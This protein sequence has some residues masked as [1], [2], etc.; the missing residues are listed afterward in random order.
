MTWPEFIASEIE[1]IKPMMPEGYVSHRL[2]PDDA[3]PTDR[4]HREAWCDVTPE[5]VI[6]IDPARIKA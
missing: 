5:L 6:D 4:T 3:I 2:M 1:K